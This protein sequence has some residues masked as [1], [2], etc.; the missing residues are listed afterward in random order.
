MID[1][2]DDLRKIGVDLNSTFKN[3]LSREFGLK[4]GSRVPFA[5]V[6]ELESSF[7]FSVEVP[8]VS[9][10]DVVVEIENNKLLVSGSSRRVVDNCCKDVGGGS[11]SVNNFFRSFNI[12][13][14]ANVD[15]VSASY[16][17]GILRITVPKK[18]KVDSKRR[19]DIS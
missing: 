4:T 16:D 9:R 6:Q 2:F 17:N 18:E 5:D 13:V 1:F 14:N 19:I 7:L 10:E 3:S 12:P 11:C 15:E 8:G